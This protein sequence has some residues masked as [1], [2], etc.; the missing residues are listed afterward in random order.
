MSDVV[1]LRG[2][3]GAVWEMTLPLSEHAQKQFDAGELVQVNADGSPYEEPP[4]PK[5]ARAQ[6]AAAAGA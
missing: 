6:R 2:S 1:F 4:A 5:R 3:G